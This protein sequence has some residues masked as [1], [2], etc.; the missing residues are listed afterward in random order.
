MNRPNIVALVVGLTAFI[1]ACGSGGAGPASLPAAFGTDPAG[2]N[3]QTGS[4]PGRQTIGELCTIACARIAVGCPIGA[5][6]SCATDCA[7]NRSLP[8]NCTEEF[9]DFLACVSTA[10]LSC[11]GSMPSFSGCDVEQAAVAACINSM[12]T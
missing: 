7:N 1:P 12:S 9:R 2:G 4:G 6:S 3:G 10:P 11:T 8:A 5:N